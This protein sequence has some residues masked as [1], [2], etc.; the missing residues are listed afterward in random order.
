MKLVPS[1]C[2]CVCQCFPGRIASHKNLKGEVHLHLL[3]PR[4]NVL[5]HMGNIWIGPWTLGNFSPIY[6]PHLWWWGVPW[7]CNEINLF[8][9][10]TLGKWLQRRRDDN[11]TGALKK[12]YNVNWN[13]WKGQY[14]QLWCY[15]KVGRA[16]TAC[17]LK[18]HQI[19]KLLSIILHS[20][21][22]LPTENGTDENGGCD[23]NYFVTY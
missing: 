17:Q 10:R 15:F 4:Y 3:R 8:Q 12:Y 2:A 13:G 6:G 18:N 16:I 21:A 11:I 23:K 7:R 14:G 1:L 9:A 22:F 5:S 20:T 19:F